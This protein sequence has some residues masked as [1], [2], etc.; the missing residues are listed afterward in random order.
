MLVL[1][2]GIEG[3]GSWTRYGQL[4]GCI[5]LGYS[6][7]RGRPLNISVN[8]RYTIHYCSKGRQGL[9]TLMIC[10]AVNLMGMS[11]KLV[12]GRGFDC[13]S[14]TLLI[15]EPKVSVARSTVGCGLM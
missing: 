13:P 8:P 6:D 11:L 9:R 15:R 14:N 12:K 5:P 3:V 1:P 10:L 2:R 7:I 4:S